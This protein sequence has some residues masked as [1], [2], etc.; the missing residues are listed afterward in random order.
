MSQALHRALGVCFCLGPPPLTAR[1]VVP[2]LQMEKL[3]RRVGGNDL[4][5]VTQGTGVRLLI[6]VCPLLKPAA[7][8][9]FW[10]GQEAHVDSMQGALQRGPVSEVGRT[11]PP[12]TLLG[13]AL[14]G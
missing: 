3:R 9:T 1:I 13:Q 4:P 7:R 8:G 11:R 2:V 14:E 12:E 10:W 5:K 6:P